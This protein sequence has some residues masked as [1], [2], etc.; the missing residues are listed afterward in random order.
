MQNQ[1][2]I[3]AVKLLP[4]VIAIKGKMIGVFRTYPQT[5]KRKKE[6]NISGQCGGDNN[7]RSQY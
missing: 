1:A 2:G 3:D 7:Q 6:K 4:R 5:E